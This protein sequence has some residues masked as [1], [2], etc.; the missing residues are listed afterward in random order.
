VKGTSND[1]YALPLCGNG[2]DCEGKIGIANC[3]IRRNLQGNKI[4]IGSI[5]RLVEA[6]LM[7]AN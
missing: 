6:Y 4:R 1:G 2:M 3:V 5:A 7:N